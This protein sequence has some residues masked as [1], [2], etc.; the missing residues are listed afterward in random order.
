MSSASNAAVPVLR[1]TCPARTQSP[2]S[3]ETSTNPTASLPRPRF[4]GCAPPAE[5]KMIDNTGGRVSSRAAITAV[6]DSPLPKESAPL[7]T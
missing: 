7:I 5:T 4:A 6:E 2:P 3:D 1:R